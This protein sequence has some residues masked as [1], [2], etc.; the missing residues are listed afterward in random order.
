MAYGDGCVWSGANGA[1]V[2][3][4]PNPP[5]DGIFQT[6]MNGKQISHRQ[7]P[8]GPKNDGGSCHGMAW[9]D[10]KLWLYVQPAWSN[11]DAHRSQKLAGGLHVPG[12]A[13]C[14]DRLH[15]IEC[16]G[17]YIWQVCGTQDPKVPGYEGYTPGPGQI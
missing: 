17:D 2:K 8:F 12:H 7:I 3:S 13:P 6:D 4:I 14:A 15:G 10:G 9:Q 5:V 1:S 11:A 16:D